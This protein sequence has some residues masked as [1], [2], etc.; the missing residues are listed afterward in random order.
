MLL[1]GGMGIYAWW[2][3]PTWSIIGVRLRVDLGLLTIVLL[4]IILR[5]PFTLAYARERVE[6][7]LWKSKSFTHTNY[8]ITAVWAAAFLIMVIADLVM[9]YIPRI[10]LRASIV[11]TI[12]ALYAAIKFT[13]WYPTRGQIK[14]SAN[15]H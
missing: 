9:L 13:G 10:P 12:I 15:D 6:P 14:S 11:V 4:S 5:H 7:S 2:L 3:H 1:F 8:V